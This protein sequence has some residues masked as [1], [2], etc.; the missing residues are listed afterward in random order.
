MAPTPPAIEKTGTQR[1]IDF[2]QKNLDNTG[3]KDV[4][5]I[6]DPS[7]PVNKQAVYKD[8]LKLFK[9]DKG[10][11]KKDTDLKLLLSDESTYSLFHNENLFKK[12]SV[13]K[14]YGEF[15]PEATGEGTGTGG[16]KK[17]EQPF[18]LGKFILS[19]F[20]KGKNLLKGGMDAQGAQGLLG[21]FIALVG[22]YKALTGGFTGMLMSPLYVMVGSWISGGGLSGSVDSL[23]HELGKGNR[24]AAVEQAD[25]FGERKLPHQI[26]DT[27]D[28]LRTKS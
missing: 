3:P 7:K 12:D 22:G 2:I 17:K 1:L 20:E 19:L 24:M 5:V 10:D 21:T 9:T 25:R 8:L 15:A 14:I 18:D 13:D 27:S 26:A 11:A 23:T 4:V 28:R 16:K 6:D